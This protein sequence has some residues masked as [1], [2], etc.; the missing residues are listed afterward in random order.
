MKTEKQN[1]GRGNLAAKDTVTKDYIKD[2][3]V[4]ADAFNFLIF[5]G[6]PVIDPSKLHEMDAAEIGMP[7][8]EGKT[9]AT[10]EKFRDG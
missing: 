7:Y 1:T 9:R 5:E 10:V 8:G 3:K 6:N 4:F 2:A